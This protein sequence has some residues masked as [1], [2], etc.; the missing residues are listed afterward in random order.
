MPVSDAI[1][2]QILAQLEAMQVSQQTMQ[3]KLDAPSSPLEPKSM[4]GLPNLATPSTPP[5]EGASTSTQTDDAKESA[6][7]VQAQSTRAALSSAPPSLRPG[8]AS[9]TD[10]E[11]EKLLVSQHDPNLTSCV[12]VQMT[13][14]GGAAE[15]G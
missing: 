4:K 9:L 14:A 10:K 7:S 1:L 2:T 6:V 12:V 5:R 8:A 15:A 11:R 13:I 3:A